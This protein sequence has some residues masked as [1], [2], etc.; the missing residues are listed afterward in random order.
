[1]D[2]NTDIVERGAASPGWTTR[3]FP[4]RI[5]RALALVVGS[6]R[7][8]LDVLTSG[9]RLLLARYVRNLDAGDPRHSVR[10]SLAALAT[11]LRVSER[12]VS[13][14]KAGL[15]A[16]G[17]ITS[18][19]VQSRQRGMQICDVTLTDKA[20]G[21]LQLVGGSAGH[22]RPPWAKGGLAVEAPSAEA[23]HDGADVG[24]CGQLGHG[25]ASAC[26]TVANACRTSREQPLQGQPTRSG[27]AEIGRGNRRDDR[28]RT[29]AGSAAAGACPSTRRR[30]PRLPAPLTW[31]GEVMRPTA[32]CW[33]MGQARHRGV[34]LE[35]VVAVAGD[36]VRAASNGFAYLRALLLQDR[37]W[38]WLARERRGEPGNRTWGEGGGDGGD[39]RVSDGAGLWPDGRAAGGF[40][41]SARAQLQSDVKAL[42]G[43][44]FVG[45]DG[46][47]RRV[48]DGMAWVFSAE[49]ARKTLG[50]S[51]GVRAVSAVFLDAVADGRLKAW[52][53]AVA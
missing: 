14:L 32:V 50:R 7:G 19:Q 43:L 1:M 51:L 15:I 22:D 46:L 5:E 8:G 18:H 36:H 17:W 23:G 53:G 42:Q 45:D 13:T 37:D 35:D 2:G 4:E 25:G 21:A 20:L 40:G 12:T 24:A 41:R 28:A 30:T 27:S 49:E 9:Q 39:G 31:L 29:R 16:G 38:S 26:A 6:D 44:S 33:L 3:C 48:S 52:S 34:R 11:G 47:V 10:V